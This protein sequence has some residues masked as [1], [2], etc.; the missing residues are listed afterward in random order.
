M[1][2]DDES[3]KA[4]FALDQPPARDAHFSTAV[5]ERVMRRRFYEEVFLLSVL[6]AA[7]GVGLWILWPVLHPMLVALSQGFAPALGAV[8]LGVCAWVIL[9]GR[10]SASPGAVT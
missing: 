8:A 10:L 4:L 5:M 6:S 9:G 7:G 1:P 3:L 2:H